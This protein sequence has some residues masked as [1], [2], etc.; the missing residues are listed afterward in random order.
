MKRSV[1]VKSGTRKG[2]KVRAHK[3]NVETG[4]TMRPSGGLP[5]Q[6]K[7]LPTAGA[8]A[9]KGI[10]STDGTIQQKKTMRPSG[11]LPNQGNPTSGDSKMKGTSR[12]SNPNP[13]GAATTPVVKMTGMKRGKKL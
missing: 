3:R 9:M 6:A 10:K 7:V 1:N 2:R 8:G 11:G 4:K 12:G 13:K 5:G